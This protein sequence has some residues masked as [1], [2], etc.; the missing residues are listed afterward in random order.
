MY[1]GKKILA[2]IPARGGSKGIIKKNLQQLGNVPLV[3]WTVIAAK[4]SNYIDCVHVSTD[5]EE[6]FEL[7]NLMGATNPFY[8]PSSI[9]QDSS[10]TN[11]AIKFSL[12]EFVKIGQEFDLVIELQP[13]YPFRLNGLID[14][15]IESFFEYENA[16]SLITVVKIQSTQHK[17][18]SVSINPIGN[19]LK[20]GKNPSEFRRQTLNP[21]YS[22][23]GIFI[24][25]T[26]DN[27][28]KNSN[29]INPSRT[30]GYIINDKIIETDINESFDLYLANSLLEY[31]G[32]KTDNL[33]K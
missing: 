9:S 15:C 11:Q 32:I 23:H 24:C 18:Y 30:I 16:D 2:I 28:Y 20:F 14:D 3:E 27:F 21:E 7:T 4:Y 22:C 12:D 26:V 19:F 29:L 1:N 13:T 33:K 31:Y 8:R 17:E 5:D 6:I 25:S 10:T